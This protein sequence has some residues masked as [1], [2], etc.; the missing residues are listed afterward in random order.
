MGTL[1]EKECLQR[2]RA[3]C[4]ENI[5]NLNVWGS[6]LHDISIVQQLVNLEV[7]NLS[8]NNVYTLQNLSHCPR[9]KE[10]YLRK[11]KISDLKEIKF[12]RNLPNLQVLWIADN[13]CSETNE[14]YRYTVLKNLPN[15]IKLDSSVVTQ[16]DRELAQERGI[17]YE[18]DIELPCFDGLELDK[19]LTTEALRSFFKNQKS[20]NEDIPNEEYE[21]VEVAEI[22][23]P[24]DEELPKD[25]NPSENNNN[26]EN[27]SGPP[28]VEDSLKEVLPAQEEKDLQNTST[29]ENEASSTTESSLPRS[30]SRKSNTLAAVLLLIN[31]LNEDELEEVQ[32]VTKQMLDAKS[33]KVTESILVD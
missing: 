24:P 3:A 9:I 30:L 8:V 1:K 2:S 25:N 20:V 13:P 12:L 28:L 21:K 14:T 16:E 29:I 19:T 18:N 4:L 17:L 32:S 6:G 27:I 33:S 11:N 26:I 22:T 23:L 10:I 7:L 5:R 15:L 31:D